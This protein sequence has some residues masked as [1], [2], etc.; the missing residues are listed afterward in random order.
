MVL[1]PELTM[2]QEKGCRRQ[3]RGAVLSISQGELESWRCLSNIIKK[4]L[5]QPFLTIF[6]HEFRKIILNANDEPY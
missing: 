1:K 4:T 3:P 5:A 2:T 6:R